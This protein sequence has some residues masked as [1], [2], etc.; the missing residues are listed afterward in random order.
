[1]T[2]RSNGDPW[3]QQFAKSGAN[4]R[5]RRKSA[6]RTANPP[7]NLPKP[8]LLESELEKEQ[9]ARPVTPLHPYTIPELVKRLGTPCLVVEGKKSPHGTQIP[10]WIYDNAIVHVEGTPTDGDAAAVVSKSGKF[11][12]AAVF[13]SASKIRA[14]LF[15]Y[16]LRPFDNDYIEQAIIGAWNRRRVHFALEDSF[17]VIFSEADGVPGL[18]VDKLADVLV[19]QILTLAVER[20]SDVVIRTLQALFAPRALIIRRDA[21]SR[22]KEGLDVK[23]PEIFGEL[24]LPHAVE[25]DGIRYFCDPVHGQKT[26][27]YLDQRFNRRLLLPWVHRKKVLDLFCHVGGWAL[28]AAK[29]GAEH[30]VGVDSA[31]P[32]IELARRS[33]QAAGFEQVEFVE[34]DVF[35]FLDSLRQQRD[36]QFDVIIADP[37]AFAKSQ[38]HLPEAE[39]AYLS[40]NYRAMKL[41][42]VGGTLVT[43]SCSQHL[44]EEHFQ[45]LLQTAARNARMRFQLMARGGQPPDHPELLGFPE[46]RYLK[47]LFLRRIE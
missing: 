2:K 13:N 46:S 28:V 9:Q 37:P 23:E 10:I 21:P 43:C 35:D 5:P 1:M 24:E 15:S 6:T 16:D 31:R 32:A 40:L 39:R 19:I 26:G 18:I 17:R 14:R 36:R 29:A 44:S 12:G 30:V 45:L 4:P 25:Q 33:V 22:A 41:L 47:C 27:L 42:P 3:W 34:S 8:S 38:K 11:F 7:G 20:R